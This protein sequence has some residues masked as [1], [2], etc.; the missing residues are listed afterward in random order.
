MYV[1]YVMNIVCYLL[2]WTYNEG[3]QVKEKPEDA[4]E[5]ISKSRL[6]DSIKPIDKVVKHLSQDL[7][8]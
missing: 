4:V 5:E 3:G 2:S 6:Q 1:L 8:N 7:K